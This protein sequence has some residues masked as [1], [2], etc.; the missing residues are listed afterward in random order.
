MTKDE[1]CIAWGKRILRN[2][3]LKGWTIKWTSKHYT[4]GI[5]LLDSKQILI[6][7]PKGRPNYTL[8]L[9][10]IVHALLNRGGHDSEYAHQYMYLVRRYFCLKGE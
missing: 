2:L 8:M 5:A 3:K 9:H 6:Y 1:K 4:E 10:E 7:W